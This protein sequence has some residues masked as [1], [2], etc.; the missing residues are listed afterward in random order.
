MGSGSADL[1]IFLP[2]R[3][4]PACRT[5]ARSPDFCLLDTGSCLL[6]LAAPSL[7]A[8]PTRWLHE[9]EVGAPAPALIG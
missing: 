8:A 5:L 3:S 1:S 6:L 4:L 9:A 7:P 2:Q